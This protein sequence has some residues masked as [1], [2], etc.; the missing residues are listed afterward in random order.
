M[1]STLPAR[2]D[3]ASAEDAHAF[4]RRQ[5]EARATLALGLTEL[6]EARHAEAP[7]TRVPGLDLHRAPTRR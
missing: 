7:T 2:P 3:T 6:L 5:A 1:T 4:D